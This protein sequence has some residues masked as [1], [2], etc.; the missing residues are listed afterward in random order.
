MSYIWKM[1]SKILFIIL[2]NRK[3]A[4]GNHLYAGFTVFNNI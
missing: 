2:R 3:K 1:E 4:P